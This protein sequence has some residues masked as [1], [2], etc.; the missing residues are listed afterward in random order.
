M[1]LL[2]DYYRSVLEET[3]RR[4][5][6]GIMSLEYA[7]R[8]AGMMQRYNL[9]EVLDYGAGAG[10]LEKQLQLLLPNVTVHNYDPGVIKWNALPKPCKMVACIDVIEHI[11]PQFL[12]AV[13]DDLERV[14]EGYAF[15]SI[16]TYPASRILPNGW[17]AH[18]CI[19]DP[20]EWKEIFER[21]FDILSGMF[22]N[23]AEIEICKKGII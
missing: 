20:L 19:K 17:N 21:R 9:D 13:L 1:N 11:E 4:G 3:H 23:N 7:P 22:K 15:I 14:I 16:C 18:I 2:S 8:V 6:W 10:N 12:D 5:P